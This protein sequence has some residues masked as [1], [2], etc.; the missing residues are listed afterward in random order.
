[1]KRRMFFAA[2]AALFLLG[3]VGQPLTSQAAEKTGAQTKCPV[4][5]G[6]VNQDIHADYNGKRIYFCCQ[7]CPGE[8]K[9]DPDKHMKK[10]ENEGVEL[11]D[12]PAEGS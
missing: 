3:I 5:G 4:M 10:L 11:E 6:T 2:L 1:M 12:A 9:K 8:F 7:A